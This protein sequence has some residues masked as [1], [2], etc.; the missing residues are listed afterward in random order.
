MI[1]SFSMKKQSYPL[2]FIKNNYT[3]NRFLDF[4]N[5]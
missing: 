5:K 4:N 2:D 3:N 1:Y